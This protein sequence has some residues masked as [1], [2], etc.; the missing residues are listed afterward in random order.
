MKKYVWIVVLLVCFLCV[1][2]AKEEDKWTGELVESADE[3][4]EKLGIKMGMAED[5]EGTYTSVGF[6]NE[7]AYDS[8]Q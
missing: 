1:G 6:A 8:Y 2:C 3:V 4:E 7:I 5:V